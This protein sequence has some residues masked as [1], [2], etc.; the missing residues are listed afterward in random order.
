M[1]RL[2]YW[3]TCPYACKVIGVL[4]AIGL[5]GKVE[6]IP[7]HPWEAGSPIPDHNPLHKIPILIDEYGDYFYDSR[8]ICEYLDE[9]HSGDKLIPSVKSPK[10]WE[11]L[12]LQALADG[13][14]D[15]VMLKLTEENVRAANLQSNKWMRRQ[16]NIIEKT[17][18]ELEKLAPAFYEEKIN[19]GLLAISSTLGYLSYRYGS[20]SW[21]GVHPRLSTWHASV[22]ESPLYAATLP[23]ESHPLPENMESLNE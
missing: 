16:Q 1:M 10:R 3:P 15:A 7:L 23:V 11:V 18:N 17:L 9:R 20:G 22:I 6:K 19:L 4:A 5:E 14:N 2:I 12:R 8:V 13:V 21:R